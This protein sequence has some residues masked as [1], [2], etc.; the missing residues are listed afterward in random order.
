MTGF[1]DMKAATRAA[2]AL[3]ERLFFMAISFLSLGIH[4]PERSGCR[5]LSIIR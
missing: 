4:V 3:V 2:W 5:D 1:A